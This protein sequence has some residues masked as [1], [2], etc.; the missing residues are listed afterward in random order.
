MDG[1]THSD[2]FSFDYTTLGLG[3]RYHDELGSARIGELRTV[4]QNKPLLSFCRNRYQS[5]INTVHED[6][7]IFIRTSQA[8]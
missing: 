1:E 3:L 4:P 2:T 7:V 5:Y 8:H 6:K